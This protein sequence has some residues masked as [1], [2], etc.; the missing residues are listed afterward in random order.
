V[1]S[2]QGIPLTN[3]GR[4]ADASWHG[5]APETLGLANW[6]NEVRPDRWRALFGLPPEGVFVITDA[7][8]AM[9][10][11]QLRALPLLRALGITRFT[12]VETWSGLDLAPFDWFHVGEQTEATDLCRFLPAC[13]IIPQAIEDESPGDA[14]YK[15]W[16]ARESCARGL[17]VYVFDQATFTRARGRQVRSFVDEHEVSR[18]F[19]YS[20]LADRFAAVE[21][22]P[23]PEPVS[24]NLLWR[25][26]RRFLRT[27]AEA[28]QLRE[29]IDFER[30]RVD[31]PIWALYEHLCERAG[32]LAD[33]AALRR[34]LR[35][36]M[37]RD[38]TSAV[39]RVME[40]LR[41]VNFDRN[42]LAQLR[43]SQGET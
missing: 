22:G 4:G 35:P 10:H 1:A 9:P 13:Q 37:D 2:Q 27:G 6:P 21:L 12:F 28:P 17:V 20:A 30:H 25:G 36:W 16:L 15:L 19:D 33:T 29:L 40:G 8:V 42:E 18:V 24:G 43:A 7:Q 31:S 14:C 38:V 3:R 32:P 34:A 26:L 23:D 39:D 11:G 5:L 41:R